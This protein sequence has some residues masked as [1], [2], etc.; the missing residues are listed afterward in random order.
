MII[1]SKQKIFLVSLIIILLLGLSVVTASDNSTVKDVKVQK[2]VTKT[3]PANNI[4]TKTITKNKESNVTKKVTNT[5]EKSV[6]NISKTK[7]KQTKKASSIDINNYQELYNTL[8]TSTESDLT[9]NLKGNTYQITEA[10]GAISISDNIKKLVINGNNKTIDGNK[11]FNFLTTPIDDIESLEDDSTITNDITINDLTIS[12][13]SGSLSAIFQMNVNLTLNHVKFINNDLKGEDIYDSVGGALSIIN[14]EN[15]TIN[16]CE[17]EKNYAL[18]AG[19]VLIEGI[20]SSK[21]TI[22][23]TNF[24]SNG[25]KDNEITNIGGALA[26]VAYHDNANVEIDNC[27]F[28]NNTGNSRVHYTTLEENTTA[29][30]SK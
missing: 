28:T 29:P 14:Y 25:K 24:T 21:L 30:N 8:T 27:K 17:F 3:S 5:K 6:K 7:N 26:I 20:K 15:I 16:N 19:A 4:K 23:N 22:N 10:T 11:R 12:N 2:S 9:V 1:I 13:C 18:D